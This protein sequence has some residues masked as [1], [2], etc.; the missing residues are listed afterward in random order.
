MRKLSLVIVFILTLILT[1]FGEEKE[2]LKKLIVHFNVPVMNLSNEKGKNNL[3]DIE[4][5]DK[6]L[7][8]FL[9][10]SK[11]KNIERTVPTFKKDNIDRANYK[12]K[13][14]KISDLSSIYNFSFDEDTSKVKKY[15]KIL[16]EL[17]NVK[18]VEYVYHY[19][20]TDETLF[21]N[22]DEFIFTDNNNNGV[23]DFGSDT[24]GKQ[25]GLYDY[26]ASNSTNRA[27]VKMPE[28]W[29][30]TTGSANTLVGFVEAMSAES[31]GHASTGIEE[32]KGRNA[33]SEG[34]CWGDFSH[35][36]ATAGIAVANTNNDH[37]VSG[38]DWNAKYFSS[39]HNDNSDNFASA[40]QACTNVDCD[41]INNSWSIKSDDDGAYSTFLAIRNAYLNGSL[42][43]AAMG[44][45]KGGQSR[46][47]ACFSDIVFSVAAS[48]KNNQRPDFSN[49]N[50]YV[51][52]A[53]PG[54][55]NSGVT[56]EDIRV[57]TENDNASWNY[58][59]SFSAPLV[60]GVAG[61]MKSMRTDVRAEDIE[62]I[63]KHTAIDIEDPGFD[64]YTGYGKINAH[65]AVK[66]LSNEYNMERNTAIGG[67]SIQIDNSYKGFL[68]YA[69]LYNCVAKKYRIEKHVTFNETYQVTPLVWG[70]ISGTLGVPPSNPN[71]Q[72]PWCGAKEGTIT[73]TGAT[74]ETYVYKCKDIFDGSTF[75]YPCAPSEVE[76]SY[77]VLGKPAQP[78]PLS[79]L[80]SSI[81]N[82]QYKAN[83]SGGSE[84]YTDYKWWYRNDDGIIPKNGSK[85][86]PVGVWLH[87][88]Y[89]DDK[90]TIT[91]SPSYSLF[92]L[93]CRATDSDGTTDTDIYS[94]G[95][96][97]GSQKNQST[98][99]NT[100][101]LGNNLPNPF[102]PTTK[103]KFGLPQQQKIKIDVY[104]ITGQKIKTLV[105]NTMSA[106]YH[107]INWNA[108]DANG[109]KVSSG[110][111]IYQLRCGNEVFTKKM[112]FAK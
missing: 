93:K 22:D 40:V 21:P 71:Y 87:N 51:D 69:D 112:I 25:W 70:N 10:E 65:E 103:I 15:K 7:S 6:S 37:L 79:I 19:K 1:L 99:P 107:T 98:I 2:M 73:S 62:Y 74:I 68:L 78:Q 39:A 35:C 12:N 45:N 64:N 94:G 3:K 31:F 75:W 90:N 81:G 9:N 57:I 36:I 86:P 61:L 101:V 8:K 49:Y 52:V 28:A 83:V 88:S 60:S 33:G 50:H 91:F 92:S 108:T 67:T 66:R 24:P 43:V 110:V 47:P 96:W 105:D 16:S 17:S 38:V 89:W 23:Y 41:I 63:L 13:F 46:A 77:T 44:N 26:Y 80:I 29:E 85:A 82:D 111:Y 34:F 106:G 102:N 55:T 5:L 84:N 59:T 97:K 30:Y 104:S 109:A 42:I 18:K 20:R 4:V 58:G 76:F 11:I 53:A 48:N 95:I 100:I 14:F 72:V 27:D 54:G 32:L 56:S